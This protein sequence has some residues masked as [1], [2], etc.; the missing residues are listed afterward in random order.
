MAALTAIE[1]D[2]IS[3]L[4]PLHY[5]SEKVSVHGLEMPNVSQLPDL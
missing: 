5:R 2:A 1:A 4:Q 3:G